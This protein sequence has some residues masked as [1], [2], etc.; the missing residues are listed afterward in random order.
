MTAKVVVV[1]APDDVLIDG[2]R[3][4]LVDLNAEQTKI[5]SDSLLNLKSQHDIITYLWSS[6]HDTDWLLDKK[7]QKQSNHI[8]RR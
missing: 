5:I 3:L 7:I 8:Q 6:N 2:F 1:T 4:L